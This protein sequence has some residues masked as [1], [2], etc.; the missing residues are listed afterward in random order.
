MKL[1]NLE[2]YTRRPTIVFAVSVLLTTIMLL[3]L[4]VGIVTERVILIGPIIIFQIQDCVVDFGVGVEVRCPLRWRQ[5][6][7]VH[8]PKLLSELL[9]P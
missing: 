1:W 4:M 3:A 7:P 6:L 9:Q 8:R 2:F 5:E